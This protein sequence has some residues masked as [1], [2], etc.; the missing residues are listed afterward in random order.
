MQ[1]TLEMGVNEKRE[2][3][4]MRVETIYPATFPTNVRTESGQTRALMGIFRHG[5]IPPLH[6]RCTRQHD[7]SSRL[8]CLFDLPFCAAV[9]DA[10]TASTLFLWRN[11]LCR[12][13]TISTKSLSSAPGRSSSARPASSITPA[14]RP[15][16]RCGSGLRDRAGQFQPGDDHDRSGDGRL[17][18][19]SSR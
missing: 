3:T 8:R 5:V 10:L 18:P 1:K 17:S 9:T 6:R 16:R 4:Y 14:R 15:A 2:V 13:A 12:A 11:A 7:I 19:I